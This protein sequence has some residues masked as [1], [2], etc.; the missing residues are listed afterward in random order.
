MVTVSVTDDDAGVGP[1]TIT[2]IAADAVGKVTGGGNI[3]IH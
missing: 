1:A 3:V 2:L